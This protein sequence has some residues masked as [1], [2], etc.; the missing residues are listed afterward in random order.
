M[1]D[2]AGSGLFPGSVFPVFNIAVLVIVHAEA[3]PV[4]ILPHS[5]VDIP[6]GIVIY[7]ESGHLSILETAFVPAAARPGIFALTCPGAIFENSFIHVATV[8]YHPSESVVLSI[9]QRPFVV[10][11]VECL[12]GDIGGRIRRRLSLEY[13][14]CLLE[15]H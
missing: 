14:Y 13:P 10:A 2:Y 6:V 1:V 11:S 9:F 3:F 15:T 4:V 8:P 5:V 12:S 7:A